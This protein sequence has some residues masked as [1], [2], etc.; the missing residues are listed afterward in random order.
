MSTETDFSFV[1]PSKSYSTVG[2]MTDIEWDTFMTLRQEHHPSE[3][4]T[5][6]MVQY[7]NSPRNEEISMDKRKIFSTEQV[8]L[9]ESCAVES[10]DEKRSVELLKTLALHDEMSQ[11][12]NMPTGSDQVI[13]EEG[14]KFPISEEEIS[15]EK[16]LNP[17]TNEEL[18]TD[19]SQDAPESDEKVIQEDVANVPTLD[20]GKHPE[21]CLNDPPTHDSISSGHE[22]LCISTRNEKTSHEECTVD[23]PRL[24]ECIEIELPM[25]QVVTLSG[26]NPPVS[27]LRV[28]TCTTIQR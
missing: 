27:V 7:T 3:S 2:T 24:E 11:Q 6:E 10:S 26:E 8:S 19:K 9:E 13:Q 28:F 25:Q 1:E 5:D 18:Y 14:G 20:M 12:G 17:S 16:C 22:S 15:L 21:E 23:R 4:I